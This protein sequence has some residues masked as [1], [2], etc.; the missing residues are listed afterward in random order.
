M[1]PPTLLRPDEGNH[2]DG[3]P[4]PPGWHNTLQY[5]TP[6]NTVETSTVIEVAAWVAATPRAAPPPPS[7][8]VPPR[9]TSNRLRAL[10]AFVSSPVTN[11]DS[12]ISPAASSAG[13]QP[14]PACL[15]SAGVPLD[16]LPPT[17]APASLNLDTAGKPLEFRTAVTGSAKS[18]WISLDIAELRKLVQ[19]LKCI[20]AVH[21]P[22]TTPT[23]CKR[24]VKEK[25]LNNDYKRRVRWTVG[26]D[27]I[28][29]AYE[30]GTNTAGLPV[31]QTL[32]HST[33]SENALFATIDIVDFYLGALLPKSESMKIYLDHIPLSVLEE[34]D[35][36]QFLKFD[37]NNRPFMFF[38]IVKTVPGLPQSGLLSQQRLVTLLNSCDYFET[39]TPMLFRHATLPITFTLVVDDFG[40]KYDS[41]S[42]LD[43]LISCLSQKYELKVHRTGNL[44][45]YLGYTIDYDRTART[46]ELSMPDY[47][48]AMLERLRPNCSRTAPSPAIYTPPSYG[49]KSPQLTPTDAS[50]DASPAQKKIIERVVG[51]L[52]FYARAVDAS[53]LTAVGALS[54]HQS[55]PTLTHVA[56]ADRL[57]SYACSHPHHT[58]MIRPSNMILSGITDGSYL[59]RPNSGSVAG[60]SFHLGPIPSAD[61][62]TPP[63]TPNAPLH[64]FSTRIPVV[65]ASAAECEYAAAFAGMQVACNLRSV[66]LDYGYPQPSTPFF[67]DNLC[68]IG[69]GTATVRPKKS[70]SIDMRLDW[71]KDR[72]RQ[73]LFTMHHVP[74][75]SNIADFFTKPLPVWRH[76][77][78]TPLLLGHHCPS[79]P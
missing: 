65:V 76:R 9:R 66:L 36:S 13:A 1:G 10:A 45:K 41:P 5:S 35:I 12:D 18:T 15:A 26:G 57:L 56:A 60:G 61:A 20:I 79:S 48:P 51:S 31:V 16:T 40:I 17:P 73:G 37:K 28:T 6:T 29:V 53:F 33:V 32:F 74:G 54:A 23:Y 62:S 2:A 47:I 59:S 44:Y 27:R 72:V 52:L 3:P 38:D 67:V 30:V 22:S 11:P 25:W 8:L 43:H 58:R 78:L 55:S 46:L 70:K 49:Q 69:L 7:Q 42:D 21:S 39:D 34:L 64:Q 19:L 75:L 50:P 71:V 24:V 63:H 68:A 14:H 77:Q 4:L